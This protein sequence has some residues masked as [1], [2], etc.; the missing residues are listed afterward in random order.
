ML[1]DSGTG[2]PSV[3]ITMSL[4]QQHFHMPLKIVSRKFGVCTTEFKKLCRRFGVAKWPHRQ[5]RGI[6]KKIAALRAELTY[7]SG[8]GDVC[9]RLQVLEDEKARL[10]QTAATPTLPQLPLRI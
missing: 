5:L 4:L 2:G 3:A 9:C 1:S 7:L 10:L 8:D 6:D